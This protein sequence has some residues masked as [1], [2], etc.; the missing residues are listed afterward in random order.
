MG[1]VACAASISVAQAGPKIEFGEDAWLSIGAGLRTSITLTEDGAPNGTS[2]STD[3]NVEN[4]RLYL[5][6][7]V[8]KNIGLTFNTERV[9]GDVDVLDAIARLEFNEHFNIWLG[10]LLTPAD[11]IELNGPFYALTWNQYTQPLFPSDQGGQA[12]RIG[13][14]EGIVAWGAFDKFQYAVGLFDGLSGF[15]NQSDEV[16]FAGRVA[17][18]FL[19][20]EDNPGYYTSSTYYGGLGNIFTVG[21]SYQSQSDG[22]GNVAE[23]GDFNGLTLD[24]LSENVFSGGGVFTVEAEYKE[25]DSDFTV[26]TPPASV[27][28]TDACFCLFD[29]DS[30][31]VSAAYLFPTKVGIGQF[32]PYVRFVENN[33]SDAASNDLV[34]IGTNY[35]IKGHNARL[36]INYSSGDANASGFAGNDVDTLLFGV[37]IQI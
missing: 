13:R 3:F 35:V 22:V 4:I 24:V 25:F 21:L 18:N 27:S 9:D 31:F 12:G 30:Y 37:Q 2:D 34:E 33:P 19:N 16:L 20:K 28:A 23:A 26:A 36:N 14:D 10:R 11:R 8:S 32:Q 29:G 6:G 15:S 7:Q 1:V 5:N 17:Y